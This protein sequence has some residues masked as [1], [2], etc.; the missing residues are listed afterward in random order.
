MIVQISDVIQSLNGQTDGSEDGNRVHR[1]GAPRKSITRTGRMRG[2]AATR[3]M[4]SV[5]ERERGT[6]SVPGDGTVY[7]G[8]VL[9]AGP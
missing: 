1:R 9:V 4:T 3:T 6:R 7:G 8:L 2:G 5:R